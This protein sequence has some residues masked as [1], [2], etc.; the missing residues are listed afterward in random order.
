MI[1]DNSA[2]SNAFATV[3]PVTGNIATKWQKSCPDLVVVPLKNCYMNIVVD[4]RTQ[5]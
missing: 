5:T 1:S 4:W 2:F 3:F